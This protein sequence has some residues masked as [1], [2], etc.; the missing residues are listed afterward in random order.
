MGEIKNKQCGR[1]NAGIQCNT[2]DIAACGCSAITLDEQTRK[3]LTRTAYDCLCNDCLTEVNA[4]V[5]ESMEDQR[6]QGMLKEGRHYYIEN[7]NW[8]FTELAHINRGFCCRNG[9]KHC[10]YG[11]HLVAGQA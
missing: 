7:G 3:F 11:N 5:L 2:L 10:A 9:C 8:I 1:C 6:S 4:L